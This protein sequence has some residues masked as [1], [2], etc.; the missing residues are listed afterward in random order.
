MKLSEPSGL[1]SFMGCHRE[2][3]HLQNVTG[4]KNR[5]ERRRTQRVLGCGEALATS[6]G[7]PPSSPTTSVLKSFFSFRRKSRVKQGYSHG[8]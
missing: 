8:G 7:A 1:K 5:A 2:S 4:G 6:S 3:R